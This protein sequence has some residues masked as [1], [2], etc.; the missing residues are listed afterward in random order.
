MKHINI[1]RT[2]VWTKQRMMMI[3]ARRPTI[4]L[5]IRHLRVGCGL[6]RRRDWGLCGD[7]HSSRARLLLGFQS[8]DAYF[9]EHDGL[10]L[11]LSKRQER[12]GCS[13]HSVWYAGKRE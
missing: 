8:F 12:L 4:L 9:E 3:K 1:S 7:R 10:T 11:A 2:M 5:G 13:A 6:R